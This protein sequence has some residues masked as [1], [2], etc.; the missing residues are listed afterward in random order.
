M[1]FS[2]KFYSMTSMVYVGTI[3]FLFMSNVSFAKTE[4]ISSNSEFDCPT[5]P[6]LTHPLYV[7][8]NHLESQ[9]TFEYYSFSKLPAP[10]QNTIENAWSYFL[11]QAEPLIKSQFGPNS[12]PQKVVVISTDQISMAG[13]FCRSAQ[14][15]S[16]TVTIFTNPEVSFTP[17]E[18]ASVIAHEFVHSY[19]YKQ[20]IKEPLWFE[21]GLALFFE[22]LVTH[23]L[24]GSAVI[25]HLKTPWTSLNDDFNDPKLALSAYGHAQLLFLYL[26]EQ[27]GG[28]LIKNILA[29]NQTGSDAFDMLIKSSPNSPWKNFG[30]AFIYFEIA[31]RINRIDY[32]VTDP[33]IQKRYFIFP[34]TLVAQDLLKPDTEEEGKPL[35]SQVVQPDMLLEKKYPSSKCFVVQN[36]LTE[37]IVITPCSLFH[38]NHDETFTIMLTP[39]FS[40]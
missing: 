29:T 7:L 8:K 22:Y 3:F 4:K 25:E 24:K 2:G 9:Y 39:Q 23:R 13:L 16:N 26:Y 28:D 10:P 19:F 38:G 30:N 20:N 18:F 40:R 27:L 34:T 6:D 1:I 21:E 11:V 14:K 17:P 5:L 12:L 37:P 36:S 31:K 15:D 35:S 33:A 32:A